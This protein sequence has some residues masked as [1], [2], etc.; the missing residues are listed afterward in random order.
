LS[1][2]TSC[3]CDQSSFRSRS[4]DSIQITEALEGNSNFGAGSDNNFSLYSLT[5]FY[6]GFFGWGRSVGISL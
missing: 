6:L 5:G 3:Q 4:A 2:K 1:V